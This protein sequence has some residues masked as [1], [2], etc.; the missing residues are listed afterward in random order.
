[1]S[2]RRLLACA[3]LLAA[4]AV[5]AQAA[6]AERNYWPARVSRLDAAGQTISWEGAG[7]FLF[8]KPAPEGGVST[9]FRP[10]YLQT[11]NDRGKITQALFAY[12][13]F[14]YAADDETF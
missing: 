13:L 9:G 11:K 6:R 5:P 2:P 1:M 3:G 4:L 7:P 8:R 14:A 10:F 12:P